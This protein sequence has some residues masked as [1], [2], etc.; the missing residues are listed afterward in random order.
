MQSENSV[1]RHNNIDLII[2]DLIKKVGTT[3]LEGVFIKPFN[4]NNQHREINAQNTI[5]LICHIRGG[6][7]WLYEILLNIPGS[8]VINEP[9]W[10]GF[11]TSFDYMPTSI[12]GKLK[13][14]TRLG[15]Y[16]EQPIPFDAKWEEAKKL[17][18]LV[19][20]GAFRNYDLYDENKLKDLS[21]SKTYITKFGYGHLLLPWLQNN[22]DL[23]SIVLHR[24]PCAVVASQFNLRGYHKMKT[25]PS[26]QIPDFKYNEIYKRY[27]HIW[28]KINSKEE[29]LA[30]IWSIKTKYVLENTD[31]HSSWLTLYYETLVSDY[32]NQIDRIQKFLN[33]HFAKTVLSNKNKPSY[34]SSNKSQPISEE[35]QL[36]KWKTI[37]SEKQINMIL[38]I[39][40]KFDIE[41]Y[42]EYLM[43]HI[44][45]KI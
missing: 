29:Y 31:K 30:A 36:R 35:F 24:H 7:T 11:F 33:V 6:S 19:L 26:G 23:K 25:S 8:I 1:S 18:E 2:Y 9:L 22:F 5:A 10:R 14:F 20:K 40:E 4:K 21:K 38:G 12:E 45:S 43:P 3:C 37:L 34:S 28:K 39:V 13:E 42:D 41:L 32:V 27:N 17:L 44:N 15:F 16:F